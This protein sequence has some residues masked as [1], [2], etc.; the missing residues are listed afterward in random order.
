MSHQ[1]PLLASRLA[2]LLVLVC[3]SDSAMLS[4]TVTQFER[5]LPFCPTINPFQPLAS[6]PPSSRALN[7]E[8]VTN[9]HDKHLR[10]SHKLE[11][12]VGAKSDLERV[13]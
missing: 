11:A 4:S 3:H 12:G 5:F 6:N 8:A 13:I 1:L 9:K 7:L 2:L 10:R